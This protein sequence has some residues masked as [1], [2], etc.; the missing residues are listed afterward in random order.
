MEWAEYLGSKRDFHFSSQMLHVWTC[1][2][3]QSRYHL[4]RHQRPYG[5]TDTDHEKTREL[6]DDII[7]ENIG[8]DYGNGPRYDIHG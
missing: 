1:D 8:V 4:I 2:D 5:A 3:C 7:I 6:L